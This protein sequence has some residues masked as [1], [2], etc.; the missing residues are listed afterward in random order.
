MRPIKLMLSS[1]YGKVGKN[2]KLL[3]IIMNPPEKFVHHIFSF[4]EPEHV[5]VHKPSHHDIMIEC[6]SLEAMKEMRENFYRLAEYATEAIARYENK[7]PEE[8]R[9]ELVSQGGYRSGRMI[10]PDE[11]R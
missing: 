10:I 4:A 9:A 5:Y 3:D 6:F 7:T 11:K 1:L 2:Y 8:L